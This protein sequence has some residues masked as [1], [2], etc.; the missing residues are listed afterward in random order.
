MNALSLALLLAAASLLG[1]CASTVPKPAAANS[2]DEALLIVAVTDRPEPRAGSG[3]TPRL[4]YRRATGYAG[5]DRA[6][7]LAAEVAGAYGLSEVSAWTIDSLALRC[8]L[9]R[10]APG[11][12]R[13]SVLA[14]LA[15]DPRVQ[16]AQPLNEFETL[17]T[18]PAKAALP[19]YNDPYLALQRGFAAIDAQAAQRATRGE[20][21]RVAVI[22]TGIDAAHPDFAGRITTQRDFV[23][24]LAT[25][26]ER[27]GTQVAGVIVAAANNSVG[28]AG[29]APMAEILSYR[30]CW[31][32]TAGSSAR[33]NSFTLA[34]AL[35][36]AISAGTDVINLSLG[37][38][39]DALLERL[40][41]H[42]MARG[43]VIVG[44][45]GT[46]SDGFPA[47]LRDVITVA[48]V[49]DAPD[50]AAG[51]TA[52][53][54][55]L[56]L[57]PGR[58]VLTLMPGGGYDFA[59]GSSMAAAHVSGAVA[60]LRSLDARLDP[61]ALRKLLRSGGAGGI[62]LCQAVRQ[63]QGGGLACSN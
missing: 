1:A 41:E 49:E 50:R 22:D 29:V 34:Q 5:S 52:P 51:N 63:L 31:T 42:A 15:Q 3:A 24:G 28:I 60:L 7:A 46:R 61:A 58:D 38:P 53:L 57:A 13:S 54:N 16:L 2:S 56:L 6:K 11:S 59:S 9:Y 40:A 37:G 39:R 36:A 44:A 32:P 62:D 25:G 43:S 23:G 4:D 8:V 48:A 19:G 20:R 17:A 30:A 27:H 33:C 26:S 35:G 12:E 10:L 55:L 47:A 21:M 45:I 18:E 14:Q